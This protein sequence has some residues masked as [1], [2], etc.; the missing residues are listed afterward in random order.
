[1]LRLALAFLMALIVLPPAAAQDHEDRYALIVG[2]SRYTTVRSLLGPRNDVTLLVN[3]LVEQG[4]PRERIRVLADTLNEADYPARVTADGL[5]TRAEIIAGL[6]WLAQ[7]AGPSSEVLIFFAGHGSQFP[8]A[9]EPDGLN[10][11]FLPID[12]RP[13]TTPGQPPANILLDDDLQPKIAAILNRGALVWFV[14]DA[15]HSGSLSRAAETDRVSRYVGPEQLGATRQMIDEARA[16]AIARGNTELRAASALDID[17]NARFIGFYAAQPEQVTYESGAPKSLPGSQR[18]SHGEFTWSL[19]QAIRANRFDS[20]ASM[21]RRVIA[22]Y[23]ELHSEVA[24]Y[25]EGSLHLTPMIGAGTDNVLPVVARGGN[26]YVRAGAIDGVSDGATIA[27]L[28]ASSDLRVL[29]R[30]VVNG[31]GMVESRIDVVERSDPTGLIERARTQGG[32]HAARLGARVLQRSADFTLMIAPPRLLAPQAPGPGD[33]ALLTQSAQALNALLPPDRQ[34]VALQMTAPDAAADIYPVV[35]N[36]RLWFLQRGELLDV[37]SDSPPYSL[38]AN[39]VSTETL[40]RALRI[41]G[42][43]RNLLRVTRAAMDSPVSRN[44]SAEVYA[45]PGQPDANGECAFHDD[46]ERTQIPANAHRL[47]ATLSAPIS[48]HCN[49][50]FIKIRNLGFEPLD[51][52]PLHINPW[53]QICFLGTYTGG[54]TE[55]LRLNPNQARIISYTEQVD[56]RGGARGPMNLLFI[57]SPASSQGP[58][59]DYRYLAA[60]G[61]LDRLELAARDAGASGFAG[62]LYSAGFDGGQTR[63]A[64]ADFSGGALAVPLIAHRRD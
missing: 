17:P 5:P 20:Y 6:D 45:V 10:E 59:R 22:Q 7:A 25:F 26:F 43:T 28:D 8:S 64:P 1:M 49:V 37:N 51:V 55:G 30:G 19:I 54:G 50:V 38:P 15:C 9:D 52:T 42:R 3:T 61:E 41:I 58:P 16:A 53:S 63:A 29:G 60:C 12:V 44:L 4:M 48:E 24:P 23:W 33:A 11:F 35:A 57:A 32:A 46:T 39:A 36:N 13:A 56:R 40:S 47:D 2:V 31:G 62:L 34:P 21:A 14:A 27:I 18:R